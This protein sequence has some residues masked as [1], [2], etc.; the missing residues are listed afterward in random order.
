LVV[1]YGYSDDNVELRGAI[2]EEVG[3]WNGATIRLT[4]TGVL[5]GP[6]CD[7]AENCNCPYFAAAKNAAKTIEAVWGAG[8]VSWTFETDIPH[9]TFNIYENG[10]L[11]CV[12]IVFRMEDL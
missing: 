10:E 7:S 2:D 1:V 12:G 9:E 11:F 5:Q 6:T 4:K 8:G 3:A